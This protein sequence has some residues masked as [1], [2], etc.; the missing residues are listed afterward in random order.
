MKRYFI[1]GCLILICQPSYGQLSYEVS[2]ALKTLLLKKEVTDRI[3]FYYKNEN[4]KLYTLPSGF[5]SFICPDS[6]FQKHYKNVLSDMPYSIGTDSLLYKL[7]LFKNSNC[8]MYIDGSI[9]FQ[10]FVVFTKISI[11]NDTAEICFFTTSRGRQER[12]K[13]K[14]VTVNANLVKIRGEWQT[15]N[16]EI[17]PSDWREYIRW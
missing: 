15:G 4:N 2:N 17:T 14:Y 10:L 3:C 13:E 8:A 6:T 16:I 12:F 5:Y 7:K 9:H 1:L 11:K